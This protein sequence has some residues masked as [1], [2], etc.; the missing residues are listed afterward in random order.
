MRCTYLKH[1]KFEIPISECIKE[2][3]CCFVAVYVGDAYNIT[4]LMVFVKIPMASYWSNLN[5]WDVPTQS[6]GNL[7]YLFL[8]VHTTQGTRF[9]FRC[10]SE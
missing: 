10:L 5:F 3:T 2:G 8:K 1:C 6:N 4:D 7:K 9:S